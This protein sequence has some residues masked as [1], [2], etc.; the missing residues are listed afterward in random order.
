[1][2]ALDGTLIIQDMPEEWAGKVDAWGTPPPAFKLMQAL[3]A[4]FDPQRRLNPGR[5]VGGL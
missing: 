5:F 4:R 3:K 2:E 1:M